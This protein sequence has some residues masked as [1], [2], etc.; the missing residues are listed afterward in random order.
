MG[1]QVRIRGLRQPAT[2]PFAV[3]MKLLFCLLGFLFF[4]FTDAASCGGSGI[5]FRFEVF[6]LS[7]LQEYRFCP[8]VPSFWAVRVPRVLVP[9]TGDR[10]FSTTLTSRFKY[11]FFFIPR[12]ALTA[13]MTASSGRAT[14]LGS[15]LATWRR[16][17]SRPSARGP[18]TRPPARG[19]SPGSA[20]CRS[21]PT[22]GSFLRVQR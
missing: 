16:R 12:R 13:K 17:G 5:P 19:L 8:L 4:S 10:A 18:S 14:S 9:T 22:E 15:A 2:A 6:F 20:V 1:N 7:T 3:A 21:P 11:Y